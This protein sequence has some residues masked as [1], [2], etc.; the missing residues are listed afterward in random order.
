M[1]LST[2]SFTYVTD[3][4]L[5]SLGVKKTALAKWLFVL[6]LFLSLIN[7]VQVL[8]AKQV[9]YQWPSTIAIGKPLNHK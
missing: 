6:I 7:E 5:S 4:F 8:F 3:A 2:V 9:I 1:W